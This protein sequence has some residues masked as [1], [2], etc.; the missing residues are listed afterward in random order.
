V[1]LKVLS[2]KLI[3][4]SQRTSL[5]AV[6]SYLFFYHILPCHSFSIHTA[7]CVFIIKVNFMCTHFSFEHC[8]DDE[9]SCLHIPAFSYSYSFIHTVL[10]YI[11]Q[12]IQHAACSLSEWKEMKI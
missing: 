8:I 10:F 5:N 11:P 2:H 1:K 7:M 3:W 9:L 6:D 4:P 12:F